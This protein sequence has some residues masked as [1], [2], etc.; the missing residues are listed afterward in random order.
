MKGR[1]S[2]VGVLALLM[3][4]ALVLGLAACGGSGD[5]KTRSSNPVANWRRPS[6]R[7]TTKTSHAGRPRSCRSR[8]NWEDASLE[9]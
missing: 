2:I 9:S 8:R 4:V 6:A 5:D 7:P 1:R 3:L